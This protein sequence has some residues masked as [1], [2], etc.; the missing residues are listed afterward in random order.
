MAKIKIIAR[1]AA[2]GAVLY[3]RVSHRSVERFVS[4]H[5]DVKLREWDAKNQRVKPSANGAEALNAFLAAV[6]S[7]AET[8]VREAVADRG[9]VSADRIA[10]RFRAKQAGSLPSSDFLT[11]AD[12][13]VSQYKKRGK[14]ST[15]QAYRTAVAKMR[16]FLGRRKQLPFDE[17]TPALIRRFET[18][19]VSIGNKPNTVHKSLSSIRTILYQAIRDGLMPQEKNPFFQVKLKRQAAKKERLS[20]DE[21][22]RI[23]ALELHGLTARVRDYWLFAFYAGGMRFSDVATLRWTHIHGGRIAYRMRKTSQDTSLVILPQAQAILDRFPKQ[24]GSRFVFPLLDRYETNTPE[25]MHKAISRSNALINK[26][27]KKIGAAAGIDTP[28]SFHMARHSLADYLRSLGWSIYDISKML[29]HASV[30]ITEAYLAGF[31][32]DDL[33]DKMRGAF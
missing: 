15:H 14:I 7:D 22:K 5:V 21:I 13:I 30:G 28:V 19:L 32:S 2:D 9:V 18:Y 8:A 24:T 3:L 20:I 4:L 29:N 17:L 33:D 31:D 27:L 23:E 26:Y 16:T 25:K 1:P 10:E 12:D 11:Y 6:R